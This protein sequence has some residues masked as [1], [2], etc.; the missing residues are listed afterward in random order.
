MSFFFFFLELD[1][2]LSFK[3]KE[4]VALKKRAFLKRGKGRG[5][6]VKA[7]EEGSDATTGTSQDE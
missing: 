5:G 6:G 3:E 7:Q 1:T 4:K 2:L